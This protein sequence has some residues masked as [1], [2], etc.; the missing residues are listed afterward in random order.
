M[1]MH[2]I[3]SDLDLSYVYSLYSLFCWMFDSDSPIEIAN[4]ETIFK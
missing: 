2:T 1:S 3:Y 4:I